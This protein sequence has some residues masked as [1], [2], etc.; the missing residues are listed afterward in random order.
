[1]FS[2]SPVAALAGSALPVRAV[3]TLGEFTLIALGGALGVAG[4]L[5]LWRR[6]K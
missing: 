4:I 6:R 2:L 5:V 1:L 3:P